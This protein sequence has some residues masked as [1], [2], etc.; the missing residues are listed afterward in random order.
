V[1]GRLAVDLAHALEEAPGYS[2][3]RLARELRETIAGLAGRR[4]RGSA[5]ATGRSG[6]SRL[7][8]VDHGPAGERGACR[9]ILG[10]DCP[11]GRRAGDG[12]LRACQAELRQLRVGDVRQGLDGVAGWSRACPTST[13]RPRTRPQTSR[14]SD[15]LRS[16]RHGLRGRCRMRERWPQPARWSSCTSPRER[17]RPR[18]RTSG[19][20]ARPID[21]TSETGRARVRGGRVRD[22]VTE[23][24]ACWATVRSKRGSRPRTAC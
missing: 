4:A 3:A 9:R 12:V 17:P 19:K 15:E 14:R 8:A 11:L 13:G 20:N 21:T 5:C 2:K 10:D 23:A 18:C 6:S 24:S 22:H 16:H 7:S 1:L